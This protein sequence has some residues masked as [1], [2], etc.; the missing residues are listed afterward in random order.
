MFILR[1]CAQNEHR[2]ARQEAYFLQQQ[3]KFG[4]KWLNFDDLGL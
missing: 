3:L 1:A 4:V 2:L